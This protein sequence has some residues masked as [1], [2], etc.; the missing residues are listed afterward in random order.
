MEDYI[1]ML[2][3]T[4]ILLFSAIKCAELHLFFKLAVGR[5]KEQKSRKKRNDESDYASAYALRVEWL[6]QQEK[7]EVL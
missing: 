5:V 4:G 7:E 6:E 2:F 1:F 3:L